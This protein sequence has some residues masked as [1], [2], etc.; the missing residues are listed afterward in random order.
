MV[1]AYAEKPTS[2][3]TTTSGAIPE[4]PTMQLRVIDECTVDAPETTCTLVGFKEAEHTW[5]EVVAVNTVGEGA[6]SDPVDTTIV[7]NRP[8]APVNIAASLNKRSVKVSWDAVPT[9]GAVE[10]MG[11]TATLWNNDNDGGWVGQCLTTSETTCTIEVGNVDG[12]LYVS[13]RARNSL[14]WSD[15]SSPR[16][17]VSRR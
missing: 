7:A 11:Y 10:L 9:S 6:P 4:T 16:A 3:P 5:V 8:A 17:E 2:R 12:P 13:V 1:N 14:G 15:A